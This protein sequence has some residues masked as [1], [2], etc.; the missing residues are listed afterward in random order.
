MWGWAQGQKQGISTSTTSA[1]GL[2]EWLD[3]DLCMWCVSSGVAASGV[4]GPCGL[5]CPCN[6]TILEG[7][8]QG[9]RIWYGLLAMPCNRIPFVPLEVS[10]CLLSCLSLPCMCGVSPFSGW[11]LW[12][13]FLLCPCNRALWGEWWILHVWGAA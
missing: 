6:R 10:A 11:R 5:L 7:R 9:K 1:A 2:L 8:G 4:V 3:R 13:C 12:A